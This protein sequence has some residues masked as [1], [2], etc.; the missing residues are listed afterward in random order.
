MCT[1]LLYLNQLGRHQ[2][3]VIHDNVWDCRINPWGSWSS[4]TGL[5]VTVTD[6]WSIRSD[7]T[8]VHFET[9]TIAQAPYVNVG[10]VD[11]RQL[12]PGYKWKS[13]VNNKYLTPSLYGDMWTA[14]QESMNFTYSMVGNS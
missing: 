8:G 13:G 9:G 14:L 2:L 4:D 7:L 10:D 6:K 5:V 12:P 1:E 3:S 11:I